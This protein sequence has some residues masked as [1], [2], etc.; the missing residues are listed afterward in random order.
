MTP[1]HALEWLDENENYELSYKYD[2]YGDDELYWQVH[3]VNGGVN[4]REW[5]LLGEGCTTLE[6]ITNAY[7]NS[8]VKSSASL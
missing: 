2:P 7:N 8:C 3:S 6:A 5:T 1:Q 4:D